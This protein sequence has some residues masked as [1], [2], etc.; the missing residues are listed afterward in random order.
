V[1]DPSSDFFSPKTKEVV[2]FIA[3]L[4]GLAWQTAAEEKAQTILVTA[5]VAM[6]L[7]SPFVSKFLDKFGGGSKE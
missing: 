4:T 7:G 2:T 6:I 1:T 5:F 3:G